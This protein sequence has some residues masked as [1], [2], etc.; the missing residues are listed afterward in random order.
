LVQ[1]SAYLNEL[2]LPDWR[3]LFSEL[4]PGSDVATE[5]AEEWVETEARRLKD[6]GELSDYSLEELTTTRVI[7]VWRKPAGS[8]A[9]A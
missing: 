6:T 4:M 9:D 5:P 1:P 7:V 8:Q 2:R 3:R